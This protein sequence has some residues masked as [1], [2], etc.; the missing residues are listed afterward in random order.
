[1]YR[2]SSPIAIAIA[3]AIQPQ[4][5]GRSI[6]G[7]SATR[8][9]ACPVYHGLPLAESL[10]M[11]TSSF[12][13]E[14]EIEVLVQRKERL[15]EV[16]VHDGSTFGDC[17]GVVRCRRST[18]AR[19]ATLDGSGRQ[20]ARRSRLSSGDGL[21]LRNEDALR[22]AELGSVWSVQR[23]AAHV[24]YLIVVSRR[25]AQRT[26]AAQRTVPTKTPLYC[27]Q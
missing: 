25:G 1:M 4:Q 6:S 8:H 20:T 14:K 17:P 16:A 26:A 9:D 7:D 13:N 15:D 3:I 10:G 11:V 22:R 18:L 24:L 12:R 27:S 23:P 2:F 5:V 21:A 19:R